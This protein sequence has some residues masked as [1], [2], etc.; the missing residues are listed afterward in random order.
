MRRVR[1]IL[2]AADFAE[3][4]EAAIAVAHAYAQAFGG[5]PAPR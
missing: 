1:E 3:L 5:R 2:V 4:A